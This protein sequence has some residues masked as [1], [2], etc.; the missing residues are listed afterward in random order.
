MNREFILGQYVRVIGRAERMTIGAIRD[1]LL[2]VAGR[3][4][5]A[6]LVEAA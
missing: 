2:F 1:G 3:W 4:W 6:W 5:P